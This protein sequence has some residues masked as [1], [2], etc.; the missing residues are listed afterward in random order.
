VSTTN[1]YDAFES[2]HTNKFRTDIQLLRAI[3]VLLVIFYHASVPH[4]GGGYI[5][6]DVFFVI[7]GFVITNVLQRSPKENAFL[8]LTT[9][10]A[11]RI[12]RLLP[13]ASLVLITTVVVTY[14]FLGPNFGIPLLSDVRFASLFSLN[15]HFIASGSTYFNPGVPPSLVTHFWSLAVEEQF[16]LVFPILFLLLRRLFTAGAKT[17]IVLFLLV[18]IVASSWWS[19]HISASN[20]V[21][22]YY[23]PFTRLWE[24]A[25]GALLTQLAPLPSAFSVRVRN[26]L[27]TVG[28]AA[29]LLSAFLLTSAS[30]YPG[31]L[32]WIPC[33]AT[34]LVLITSNDSLTTSQRAMKYLRPI[35]YVGDVSYSLYLWHFVWLMLPLQYAMTINLSTTV[36]SPGVRI[37]QVAGA[38]LC[39]ALSNRF[40]EIPIRKSERI[41]N[42]Q[43]LALLLFAACV[44]TTLAIT[45]LY[46]SFGGGL[47]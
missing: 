15:F 10:Y 25:L 40:V 34:A 18:V 44:G 2:L 20:A 17:A 28:V 26:A 22:A 43:S 45:Y 39:A 24:L 31:F 6:V 29:I 36:M 8:Q 13:A 32:A 33:A 7:S 35:V 21:A 37:T 3:A 38:F 9:F 5:G 47:N 19:V 27:S 46:G 4:F 16:Y 23:S 1:T 42:R 11:R 41:T 14:F 30:I 12:R